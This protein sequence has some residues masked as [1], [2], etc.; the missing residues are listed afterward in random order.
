MKARLVA[1]LLT[2]SLLAACGNASGIKNP[3]GKLRVVATTT[4]VGDVVE[5]IA[6]DHILLSVLIP[7][8]V[9]EHAYEPAPQDIAR[10]ANSDL[11]FMNGAGLEQF[12]VKLMQ[13]AG[14][15]ARLVSVS[16]GISLLQGPAEGENSTGG[17]PHVWTD[18]NNVMVWV[19]NIEKTLISADPANTADYQKNAIQ[20][21]Q[22]LKDLDVWVR[23]QVT[24][25][26][27]NERKL[28]TDHL[29]FTYFADRYGFEQVGAVL[30]GYST[31]A[32]PSAQEL[33]TLEDKIRE[34]GVPVIFVGNTVNPALEERVAKDTGT[35]IVRVLTGSLTDAKG[36]APTYITYMKF[37]VNAIVSTLKH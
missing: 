2:A 13:N 32:A 21:R 5:N 29:V 22:Q 24:Q 11:I 19:D 18:P 9:D 25:L 6:G 27:V 12:T 8:N 26:P 37:D 17:D 33:A 36:E 31:L 4:L 28:V 34:L 23:D 14:G 16:D 35:R 1:L 10:V 15:K 7:P 30:P 3:G 20:Y